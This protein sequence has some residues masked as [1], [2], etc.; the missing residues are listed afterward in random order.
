MGHLRVRHKTSEQ[1]DFLLLRELEDH[2]NEPEIIQPN[3]SVSPEL[4]KSDLEMTREELEEVFVNNASPAT[5]DNCCD[6][7]AKTGAL[8]TWSLRTNRRE[9]AKDISNL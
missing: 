1:R 2:I 6:L 8:F 3:A 4:Y 5:Y 9:G 7:C